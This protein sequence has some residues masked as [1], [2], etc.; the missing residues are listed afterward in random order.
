LAFLTLT[1]VSQ[2]DAQTPAEPLAP[3]ETQERGAN[4]QPAKAGEF[5]FEQRAEIE[6][7]VESLG[8]K[9]FAARERA[10]THLMELGAAILPE[11]RR[12]SK[13]SD[14]PE[15]RLRAQQIVL[16]MTNGDMQARMDDF[17]AG[18]D[19]DFEGWRLAQAVLGD[20][21]GVRELFVE[22]MKMHPNVTASLEGTTRD[23]VMAMD[24]AVTQIQNAMLNE[25]K[26]PTIADAFALLLPSSVDP[27]VPINAAFES[28]LLSVLQK[29]PVSTIG[30][31]AQLAG[32]FKSLLGRWIARST[33]ASRDDV[34]WLGMS[35]DLKATLPL[36]IQTL[37][38]ANQTE[39]LAFAL[40]AIARFGNRDHAA[41]VR[42]L[43]DDTRPSSERGFARGEM[44][45]TQLGDVAM[46]TIAV[47]YE[48][49]LSE[50]GFGTIETHPTYGFI[51]QEIGFPFE[52]ESK[53][54][55]TRA[56][57]DKL[58]EDTPAREGS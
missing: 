21:A 1:L 51:L 54:T 17:L 19:V 22:I 27:N 56:K 50:A 39:T 41:F 36:A 42:P 25:R 38:E 34:L 29:D 48:M 14:D 44:A 33:L 13:N 30:R 9:E 6:A 10:A 7:W 47:L 4:D 28:L 18:E 45:R 20:S 24:G 15:V 43:L 32:P 57:I 23:R 5:T 55:A 37:G 2:V 35:W 49:P 12:L 31:D 46:A 58:L 8:S 26:F 52:N 40:Q 53:R 11:L 16:Q 3:A